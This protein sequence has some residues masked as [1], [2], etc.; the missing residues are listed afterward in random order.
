[1]LTPWQRLAR[2]S[3]AYIHGFLLV[4][5]TSTPFDL[6]FHS[7][8]IKGLFG[9]GLASLVQVYKMCEDYGRERRQK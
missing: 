8:I 7:I 2:I 6:E 4:A 9:G 5:G 1:M 3:G